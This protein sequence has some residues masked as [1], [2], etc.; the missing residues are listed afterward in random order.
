MLASQGDNICH[1]TY[2]V[3]FVEDHDYVQ[4]KLHIINLDTFW[5][6]WMPL[7]HLVENFVNINT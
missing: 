3:P 1:R 7:K 6:D 2:V 5:G 4:W